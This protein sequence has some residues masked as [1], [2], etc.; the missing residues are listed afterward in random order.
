MKGPKM[1]DYTLNDAELSNVVGG[2]DGPGG[3][4]QSQQ[5]VAAGDSFWRI[6][7]Q[8]AGAN[9]SNADVAAVSKN[10]QT[11]NPQIKDP[12]LIHPGD[13]INTY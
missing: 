1:N 6:A 4:T 7:K 2:T 8:R 3:V 13:V 5:T 11:L 9:A 10:L 12:N